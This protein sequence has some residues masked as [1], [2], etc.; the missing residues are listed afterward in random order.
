MEEKVLILGS[1][2]MLGA[3]L[4]ENF[5]AQAIGWDKEDCDVSNAVELSEK[6]KAISHKLTAIINCVAYNDVDGA[7]QNQQPAFLLNA[8]VPKMLSGICRQLD[9]PLVH[10]STNYV[11]DGAK[12]EYREDDLPN[13]LSVYAKSKYQG[14][15]EIVKTGGKYYIVRTSVLFGFKGKSEL[16]KKSFVELMLDLSKNNPIVKVVNDEVN[17]IT[18][19]KDLALEVK[20]LFEN[21]KPF[22]VY[23]ITNGGYASWYDFAKEIFKIIGK[24][25]ILE[26][27]SAAG[28]KR[29]AHR[30][31]RSVLLNSKLQ[32]LR[33]WQEA[34]KE[35]L[36]SN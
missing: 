13:P 4:L 10:F 32:Q 12:G 17:S 31:T 25:V 16:A 8:E 5:G 34:L 36:T 29:A 15:L 11:F 21:K 1:K 30:P 2:G 23:H 27:V 28:F 9:I 19:A 14:E 7:E 20:N 33:P 18:Y 24:N 26:P 6:L 35:F 22:G 3:Q